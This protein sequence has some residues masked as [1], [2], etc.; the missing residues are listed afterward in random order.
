[1]IPLTFTEIF[2][3]HYHQLESN[4]CKSLYIDK[5]TLNY[6]QL[7]IITSNIYL[8]DVI[9]N[10]Q[11]LHFSIT[12]MHTIYELKTKSMF[13]NT[14]TNQLVLHIQHNYPCNKLI[15]VC[16]TGPIAFINILPLTVAV[17]YK[18]EPKLFITCE[19]LM[20]NDYLKLN[21]TYKEPI[22]LILR[23][24][25]IQSKLKLVTLFNTKQS[26]KLKLRLKMNN[27]F[28]QF[29]IHVGSYINCLTF[30]E[31]NKI[32][33]LDFTTLILVSDN[34]Y[35]EDTFI[36]IKYS[37]LFESLELIYNV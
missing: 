19:D 8:L 16:H 35:F 3:E 29:N 33:F 2:N 25:E 14:T 4:Y 36:F 31:L 22:I 30:E 26:I 10:I 21:V 37:D 11:Y 7:C 12:W 20:H 1:M 6:N 24:H 28:N 18:Y 5:I 15:L 13:L 17:L 32:T 9:T 23:V 27:K 34:M